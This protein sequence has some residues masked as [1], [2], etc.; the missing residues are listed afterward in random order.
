MF[1]FGRT[2]SVLLACGHKFR[3]AREEAA[4]EQLFIGKMVRCKEC[5]K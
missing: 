5:G 4:R 1:K 2:F 3:A